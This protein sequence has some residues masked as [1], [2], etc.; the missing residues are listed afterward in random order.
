M[1]SIDINIESSGTTTTFAKASM[2]KYTSLQVGIVE[3]QSDIIVYYERSNN[4]I[5]I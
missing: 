3:G 1:H 2:S 5:L 4:E